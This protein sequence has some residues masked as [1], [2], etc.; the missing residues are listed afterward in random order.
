LDKTVRHKALYV[1]QGFT[2]A[3]GVDC[4]A[5]FAPTATFVLMRIILSLSRKFNW[6]VFSFDFVAA[7]LNAPIDE[8][9]WV[10]APNGL[11]VQK[12]EAMRLHKALY[13]TKQAAQCWWLHLKGVLKTL[14]F[15]ASH[16]T[17]RATLLYKKQRFCAAKRKNATPDQE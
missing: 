16:N 11:E 3:V 10:E 14:G 5:N 8:E 17:A 13:G 7:Y 4:E 1:A 12:G 2:Q 9:V 6:P 15:E